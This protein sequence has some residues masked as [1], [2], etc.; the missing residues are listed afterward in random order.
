M[1]DPFK[2]AT[3]SALSLTDPFTFT[4]GTL[5]LFNGPPA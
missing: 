4:L 1:G 5:M 3:N 2:P